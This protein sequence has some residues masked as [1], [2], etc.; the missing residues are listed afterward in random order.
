MGNKNSRPRTE[1]ARERQQRAAREADKHR[2]AQK[3]QMIRDE[4]AAANAW[5]LIIENERRQQRIQEEIDR[6]NRITNGSGVIVYAPGPGTVMRSSFTN[7]TNTEHF[8]EQNTPSNITF[9]FIL[10]LI[11]MLILYAIRKNRLN[12]NK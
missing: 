10:I 1:S 3:D 4:R 12:N 6:N 9:Y 11:F 7:T 8:T 5:E 2:R